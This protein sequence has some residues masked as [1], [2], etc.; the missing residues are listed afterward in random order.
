MLNL[1]GH[2]LIC[3]NFF[4]GEGYDELFVKNLEEILSKIEKEYI[5]VIEGFDDVCKSCPYLKDGKCQYEEGA[6]EKIRE[7][8]KVALDLLNIKEGK[9]ITWEE[10]KNKLSEVFSQWYEKYCYTCD[11]LRTCETHQLFQNLFQ[12]VLP[13]DKKILFLFF[14]VRENFPEIKESVSLLKP[15]ANLHYDQIEDKVPFLSTYYQLHLY[16]PSWVIKR[17]EF[18]RIM[19][20][21]PELIYK[22]P[23]NAYIM[24]VVYKVDN[25]VTE[26]IIAYG[27]SEAFA[28]NRGIILTYEEVDF[29]CFQRGYGRQLLLALQYDLF[30]GMVTKLFVDRED[31]Q[32]RLDH[33]KMLLGYA[34]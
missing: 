26:G 14:K 1:R 16:S 15:Y 12:E 7:Q 17:E 2:H 10:I 33:L 18:E 5:K 30:P 4:K 13:P 3:L 25:Y 27:F 8:D 28:L 24:S 11:W 21:E 23:E 31:I 9:I 19:G 6:E 34:S 22:S 20:F 29:I 32:R